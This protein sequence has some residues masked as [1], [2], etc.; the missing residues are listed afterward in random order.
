MRITRINEVMRIIILQ[1]TSKINQKHY[2]HY[3][4]PIVA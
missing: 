4:I 3:G 2:N 1:Y